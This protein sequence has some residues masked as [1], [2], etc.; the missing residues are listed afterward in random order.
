MICKRSNFQ[1]GPLEK[2]ILEPWEQLWSLRR[3]QIK[4]EKNEKTFRDNMILAKTG[5]RLKV[6]TSK[7]LTLSFVADSV[8]HFLSLLDSGPPKTRS[9]LTSQ[10]L[11]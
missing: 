1:S 6:T 2:I 9:F 4:L 5:R 8:I 7:L 3:Q 11:K 10:I